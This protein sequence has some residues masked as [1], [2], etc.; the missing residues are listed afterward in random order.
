MF[1][2]NG[3]FFP[4]SP[5]IQIIRFASQKTQKKNLH[6]F[7]RSLPIYNV[8]TCNTQY[9]FCKVATGAVKMMTRVGGNKKPQYFL[10]L[11][12]A[13]WMPKLFFSFI[14][15]DFPMFSKL[16]STIDIRPIGLPSSR[17]YGQSKIWICFFV[18]TSC[19]QF[20]FLILRLI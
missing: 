11:V 5:R 14:I 9:F 17:D 20:F 19:S 13:F 16:Y 10:F 8:Q 3:E 1:A 2:S 4:N 7:T 18:C 15:I 12:Q 6:R